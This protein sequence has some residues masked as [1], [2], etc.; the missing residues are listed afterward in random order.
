MQNEPHRQRCQCVAGVL[1]T[2]L[3]VPV[4]GEEGVL[5][6]SSLRRV[7]AVLGARPGRLPG[8]PDEVVGGRLADRLKQARVHGPAVHG[9]RDRLHVG[10]GDPV[11]EGAEDSNSGAAVRPDLTQGPGEGRTRIRLLV[12]QAAE[13]A[14]ES[15]GLRAVERVLG[16]GVPF[17]AVRLLLIDPSGTASRLDCCHALARHRA[18]HERGMARQTSKRP[19]TSTAVQ[20]RSVSGAPAGRP[21]TRANVP[22][23]RAQPLS[24]VR[25]DVLT[26]P[27]GDPSLL[28]LARVSTRDQDPQRQVDALAAAGCGSVWIEHGVSGVAASRLALDDLLDHARGGDVVIVTELSR[29]GRSMTKT[30]ALLADLSERGVGVRS[31]TQGI[32][33]AANGPAS[34]LLIALMAALSEIEHDWLV[35]RTLDGLAAA[36]RRGVHIGR[37]AALSPDQRALVVRL[38]EGEC[39]PIAEVA[40]IANVSRA[41]VY[42]AL[43]AAAAR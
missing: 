31:L 16:H 1:R 29:I 13:S 11:D 7:D 34:K 9:Q 4:G 23:K 19:P 20:N 14:D 36:R 37:P 42:R 41:T 35:G 24:G 12:D 5:L 3:Q 2:C 39:R 10:G 32:D 25:N 21:A 6:C 43:D 40:R 33:T 26:F 22:A 27:D 28:G 17:P 30:V 15:I 38:V 18:A 8:E